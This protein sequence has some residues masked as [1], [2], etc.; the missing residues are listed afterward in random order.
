MA[1]LKVGGIRCIEETDE[2]G[3]DDI[4]LV[5]FRGNS[6]A[7]FESNISV[8]GPGSVWSDFDSGEAVA[9]DVRIAGFRSDSVYVVMLVE[10]DN[11][12]DIDGD[13]VVGAWKAQLDLIWKA[14]MLSLL[15]GGS[16]PAS[17]AVRAVAAQAIIN[18]MLGL[19]S[20]YMNFPK[21]N[22]DLIDVPKRVRI[23]PGQVLKLEFYG[24]G[25][26]YRVAFI[27]AD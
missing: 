25:G 22:D 8:K 21:G 17:E 5:T 14:Q 24:D 16:G 19:A 12:R 2:V 1:W 20:L 15:G 4:Y 26:H 13:E 6:L 27:I 9:T 10:E 18:A 23:A 7:P 11:D 3:S